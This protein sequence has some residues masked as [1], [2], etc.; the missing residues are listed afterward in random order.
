M[1][2]NSYQTSMSR[3]F[4]VYKSIATEFYPY[5][6]SQAFINESSREEIRE[7]INANQ[8]IF[9]TVITD[10]RTNENIC[11]NQNIVVSQNWVDDLS[12]LDNETW[13]PLRNPAPFDSEKRVKSYKENGRVETK[14][15]DN[16]GEII[17]RVY[18]LESEYF[19]ARTLS[20]SLKYWITTAPTKL[21][22]GR[23]NND[24]YSF[25]K[26]LVVSIALF[27]TMSA[28]G[29]LANLIQIR[30]SKERLGY[31]NS[32][33]KLKREY[34]LQ[35]S[36]NNKLASDLVG[37]H[38]EKSKM[39][40]E[41]DH[42]QSKNSN[43]QEQQ[44]QLI[45]DNHELTSKYNFIL[46]YAMANK[47]QLESEFTAPLRNQ[48]Q[49]LDLIIEGLSRR[50]HYDTRDALHDLRK[51]ELLKLTSKKLRDKNSLHNLYEQ[52]I[53]S[54][55]TIEWTAQNVERMTN[56][57]M[58]NCNVYK[59][60]SDFLDIRPPSARLEYVDITFETQSNNQLMIEANPYHIQ[61][62]VK[63]ALYNALSELEDIFLTDYFDNPEDFQGKVDISCGEYERDNDYIFI[64]IADNAGGVP[65]NFI[66]DLYESHKKMNSDTASLEGNG[67]LI[68]NSYLSMYSAKVIKQNINSGFEVTFLFKKQLKD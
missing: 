50:N 27:I 11:A 53:Q 61:A 12:M 6:I 37:L 28:L 21:V 20:S 62:I 26:N 52:L 65:E 29:N 24:N 44:T 48:L 4:N 36:E 57:N 3:V 54:R 63:N 25:T 68:V 34:E 39:L 32:T 30:R 64:K 9:N 7:I 66:D 35:K 22:D 59:I 2:F 13:V 17:G 14:L 40:L 55:K 58:Q 56:L 10:C 67:S 18:F 5:K 33:K 15:H 43:L 47:F 1:S 8:W 60:I 19:T 41:Q 16:Q 51:A 45:K 49:R 31:D 46:N 23:K 42:M 38:A